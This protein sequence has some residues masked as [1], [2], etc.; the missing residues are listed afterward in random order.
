LTV[1]VAILALIAT[2]A[3]SAVLSP[4]R[5]LVAVLPEEV[6]VGASRAAETAADEMRSSELVVP[7]WRSIPA[8]VLTPPPLPPD[9][10]V[11]A[12]TG[13]GTGGSE[14]TAGGPA[15]PPDDRQPR[16]IDPIRWL[17]ASCGAGLG[18]LLAGR[19]RGSFEARRR[20]QAIARGFYLSSIVLWATGF[21]GQSVAAVLLA[22]E[23]LLIGPV[24]DLLSR[25]ILPFSRLPSVSPAAARSEDLAFPRPALVGMAAFATLLILALA[26]WGTSHLSPDDW[27]QVIP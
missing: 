18:L 11:V 1:P 6:G 24:L 9:E 5:Q 7:R 15:V 17:L 19:G 4:V 10:Q 16:A 2:V 26:V 8:P 22:A 25:V 21:V 27:K 14:E 20:E 3:G 12:A 13:G 23:R